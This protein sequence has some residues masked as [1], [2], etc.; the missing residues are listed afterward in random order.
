MAAFYGAL[1]RKHTDLGRTYEDCA[2]ILSLKTLRWSNTPLWDLS[3][4]LF[5]VNIQIEMTAV[6]YK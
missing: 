2:S 4:E 3:T 6:L 1:L 5:D